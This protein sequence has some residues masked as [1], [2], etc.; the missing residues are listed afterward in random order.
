MDILAD[1]QKVFKDTRVEFTGEALKLNQEGY[2]LNTNIPTLGLEKVVRKPD[3]EYVFA[4]FDASLVGIID[5]IPQSIDPDYVEGRLWYD[6]VS[7]HLKYGN[8]VE[9]RTLADQL[10]VD[11]KLSTVSTDST[12]T[13]DG[14]SVS[15]LSVVGTSSSGLLEANYKFSTDATI[16]DPTTGYA[17]VDVVT[18]PP[19]DGITYT[20][21]IAEIDNDGID[22]AYAMTAIGKGDIIEFQ[23][24]NSGNFYSFQVTDS[25]TDQTG[26]WTFPVVTFHTNGTLSDQEKIVVKGA[27]RG[28]Q[29]PYADVKDPTGFVDP[30]VKTSYDKTTRQVTVSNGDLGEVVEL[31]WNGVAIP[32]IVDGYTIPVAHADVDGDYFLYYDG[33]NYVWT[34][35]PWD[36]SEAPICYVRYR[37]NSTG[38]TF[39]LHE[40]HGCNMPHSVHKLGH[41]NIGTYVDGDGGTFSAWVANSSTATDRRPTIS[42]INLMDEDVPTTITELV[43]SSTA[44]TWLSQTGAS[45]IGVSVFNSDNADFI[46][47]SGTTPRFNKLYSGLAGWV[48]EDMPNNHYQKILVLAIPVASDTDSQKYGYSFVQ[49]QE[50]NNNEGVI[51]ALTPLNYSWGDLSTVLTEFTIVG[52]IIIKATGGSWEIREINKLRINRA[53]IVNISSSATPSLSQTIAVSGVVNI[54]S[55]STIDRVMTFIKG[56]I[57]QLTVWGS[58]KLSSISAEIATL[59]SNIVTA[60][61]GN[62]TTINSTNANVGSPLTLDAVLNVGIGGSIAESYNSTSTDSGGDFSVVSYVEDTVTGEIFAGYKTW[63]DPLSNKRLRV[64][65]SFSGGGAFSWALTNE[66]TPTTTSVIHQDGSNSYFQAT[67]SLGDNTTGSYSGSGAYAGF[68]AGVGYTPAQVGDSIHA[69]SNVVLSGGVLITG[70]KTTDDVATILADDKNIISVEAS[71]LL[72]YTKDEVVKRNGHDWTAVASGNE[73]NTWVDVAYGNGLFVAVAYSGTNRVMYSRDGINW[74]NVASGNESNE[75]Y[76]ITYGNGLFVAVAYSGTN[77]VMYSSDGI[78]WTAVASGNESNGWRGITYGNG[79][80]VAVAFTGTNKVMYSSD[81]IIWTDVTSLNDSNVWIDVT[82]G[83]GLFVAVASSGTNKVMYSSDGIIWT[84]VAS[85][86]DSN[87]WIGITY[88]NGLF[89]SVAVAGTNRAMYSGFTLENIPRQLAYTGTVLATDVLKVVNGLITGVV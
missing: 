61:T 53:N 55:Y 51:K 7:N 89:V 18:P 36:F 56:G 23:D 73:S 79:L 65:S 77:K 30:N 45:D 34:L 21:S 88:G 27:L 74:E 81:G 86:N 84:D 82:Y 83:N 3:G 59:T 28:V 87:D 15:P 31:L 20:L 10:D 54:D 70:G 67:A 80:F 60:V 44:Y 76:S 33:A 1:V 12:L 32:S 17:K 43:L 57:N 78:N 85:G 16:T 58:G 9:F 24:F 52:E 46:N 49:G 41:D 48:Q 4:P 35:T 8:D 19:T 6:D 22:R 13:G 75:W 38:D 2:C 68:Q 37:E 14:T 11:N 47:Q 63:K 66:V 39:A 26:W 40:T 42:P 5:F 69:E 72:H 50:T 71:N 25:A 29:Y 64:V 62:I